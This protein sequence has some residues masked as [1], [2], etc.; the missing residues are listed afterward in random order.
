METL[1]N[2]IVAAIIIGVGLAI[3]RQRAQDRRQ[4]RNIQKAVAKALEEERKMREE[5]E[6]C[7]K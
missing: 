1:F 3:L 2:P 7:S 6:N 5:Q 4:Q